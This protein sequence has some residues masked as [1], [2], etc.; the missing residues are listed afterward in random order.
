MRRSNNCCSQALRTFLKLNLTEELDEG[1]DIINPENNKFNKRLKMTKKM[2]K[3]KKEEKELERDL[4]MAE[5]EQNREEKKQNVRLYVVV[6]IS[7][8]LTIL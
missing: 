6:N 1:D 2:K 3:K 8:L 7:S 5:A 4:R